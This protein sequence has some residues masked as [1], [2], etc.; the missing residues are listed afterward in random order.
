DGPAQT[1]SGALDTEIHV[2][3]RVHALNLHVPKEQVGGAQRAGLR[4]VSS[5]QRRSNVFMKT[6]A[7]GLVSEP[8]QRLP[9]RG[10]GVGERPMME[11][12]RI[13]GPRDVAYGLVA[14]Q[15]L[16]EFGVGADPRVSVKAAEFEEQIAFE[17]ETRVKRDGAVLVCGMRMGS[18]I[19]HAPDV[20][21]RIDAGNGVEYGEVVAK[22]IDCLLHV[23]AA[24]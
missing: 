3:S 21:G 15:A 19:Q 9:T 22:A 7:G 6:I 17:H 10:R 2:K 4:R 14:N 1:A 23:A 16:V 24:Q 20:L 18:S 13:Q 5:L 11:T 12:S 8:Q